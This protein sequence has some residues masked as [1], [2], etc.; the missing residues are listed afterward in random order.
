MTE[1]LPPALLS[2][3]SAVAADA[4]DALG[5][6]DQTMDSRLRPVDP[7]L[8]L[9][10]RAYPVHVVEDAS[11]PDLPYDGEMQALAAMGPGDVGVYAV[12]GESRAAA[13]G[14]LFSCAAIG[15]GVSGVVVD[16]CIRDS[17]QI[18]ELQYPVFAAD[19]S[20][21]DTLARARVDSHGGTVV[22]GGR[23]VRRGDVLVADADGIVVVPR[24]LADA[25]AAFVATKHRLEQG[26]RDDL[27]AGLSIREVWDKYGVF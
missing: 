6:R 27:V 22:C 20:P 16:G 14:E 1:P 17:R 8:R 2:A 23:T 24:E 19:R 9:V 25:V 13:W 10:G 4:L 11:V 15:R 26:A 3:T 7:A 12:S 18:R 5:C 21:L